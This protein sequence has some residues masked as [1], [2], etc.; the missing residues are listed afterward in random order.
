V[1]GDRLHQVALLVLVGSL[2]SNNLGQIVLVFVVLGAPSL[3]F[4]L[5]AGALVDRSDRRRVMLAADLVRVPMVIS[6]PFLVPTPQ[7]ACKTPRQLY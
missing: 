6:I 7:I 5:L 3:L 4:G 2:T 1:F